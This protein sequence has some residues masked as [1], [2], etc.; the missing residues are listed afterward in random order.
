MSYRERERASLR[1]AWLNS[2]KAG[3]NGGSRSAY[4]LG[5]IDLAAL[6]SG[7]RGQL[8]FNCFSVGRVLARSAIAPPF[9]SIGRRADLQTFFNLGLAMSFDRLQRTTPL[10]EEAFTWP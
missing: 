6:G 1:T 5:V 2:Y 8:W 4:V 3:Q 10:R 9:G 7:L